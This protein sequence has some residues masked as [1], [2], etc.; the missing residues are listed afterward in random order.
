M[1]SKFLICAV[2][3]GLTISQAAASSSFNRQNDILISDQ[4]NNRVIEINHSK[5]IV[6]S[7]GSGVAGVCNPGPGAIIAPNDAERLSD[8][9]TLIPGTGTSSCPD[10]RV[11]VVDQEGHIIFQY[12]QAGVA[13]SGPNQLNTPVFAIETPRHTFLI[14]D[15]GNNRIV[16]VSKEG[17]VVYQYGPT[18]GP[19]QLNNPN[20]AELL[21]NGDILIADEN[22][23]RVIEISPA[24]GNQIVSQ[25][26]TGLNIVAFASR[27]PDGNTLI[28]D[29]GNNRIV[30]INAAKN[31]IFQYATN[32]QAGS[33]PNP[34]PTNAVRLKNGDILIADQFNDRIFGID[35]RKK[36]LFQ[37]GQIN[38]PGNGPD[39][40]NGPYTAFM[41]GD[42]TGQTPPP[43]E[44]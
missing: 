11:I 38:V 12:G 28:T 5:Q 9:L 25:Y 17:Q 30:E 2:L 43:K 15:Q 10:N 41:I 24:K 16:E 7:F 23:S 37:Y 26:S 19:G 13:G 6:W 31:V 29:S 39:Q 3:T 40:L 42:Y 34:N 8:G 27:L 35:R 14:T 36:L 22:N 18:S 20:S 32:T 21:E 33:N 4:F 44:Y 1:R